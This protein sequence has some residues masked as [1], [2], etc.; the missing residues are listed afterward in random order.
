MYYMRKDFIIFFVLVNIIQYTI[1]YLKLINKKRLIVFLGIV[2]CFLIFFQSDI[3]LLIENFTKNRT[4]I[5][6][7]SLHFKIMSIPL[8]L[9]E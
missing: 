6:L 5:S 4:S 9:S 3:N 1:K 8:F 2:S 7:D